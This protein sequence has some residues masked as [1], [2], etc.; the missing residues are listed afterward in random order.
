MQ[1]GNPKNIQSFED[2]KRSDITIV[3]REPGSGVRVLVDEKLRQA[4]IPTQEVNGYQ[5]IVRFSSRSGCDSKQRRSRC[6]GRKRK[7]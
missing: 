5:D 2:L 4:G 1:K 6:G 3:N 7:A